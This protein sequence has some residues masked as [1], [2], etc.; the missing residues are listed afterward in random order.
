MLAFETPIFDLHALAPEIAL[1][2]G[3]CVVLLVDLFVPD[4]RRWITGTLSGFFML[5]LIH[6][7]EPTR[8]Y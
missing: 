6:I 5:S 8:P 7:S 1:A 4:S 2:V 3:I